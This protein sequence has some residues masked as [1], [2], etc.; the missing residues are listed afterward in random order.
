MLLPSTFEDAS[1]SWAV[2]FS[3]LQQSI[4][5]KHTPGN[6]GGCRGGNHIIWTYVEGV[7][8]WDGIIGMFALFQPGAMSQRAVSELA[9]PLTLR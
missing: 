7:S 1:A 3:R 9:G 6:R 2:E 5:T 8:Y 4:P